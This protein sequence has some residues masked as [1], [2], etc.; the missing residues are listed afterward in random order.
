MRRNNLAAGSTPSPAPGAPGDTVLVTG[1]STGLG[2]ETAL[3]L[4]AKGFTVYATVRDLGMK[5][6]VLATAAERGVELRVLRLDL[7]DQSS[8]DAA[9][10]QILAETGSIFALVNNGGVGLRG[11]LED[12]SDADIRAV[13][14]A[15]LFGTI[16]VTKAVLPSM[17]AA[18][19]GRVV[20]IGSVGGRV[21]S[22]GVSVY[23]SSKFAQ[24]GLA[25]ALYLELA[26]FGLH[27]ILIE[28]GII[29]TTRWSTNRATSEGARNPASAYRPLFEAGEVLA[30]RV[31]N[32]S[33][34][35]AADVADAVAESLTAAKPRLRYV[36]GQPAG[37]VILLR[38]Y[39]PNRT[40]ERVYFGGLLRQLTREAKNHPAPVPS[41]PAQVVLPEVTGSAAIAEAAAQATA[42]SSGS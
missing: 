31:V 32:R 40:F 24:E 8:I 41:V 20:T 11:C 26:P 36:V 38:R 6:E 16:A 23:C 21:S 35:T 17:R 30:D 15:N 34:T 39:L 3:G 18:G 12:L 25:E 27:S 29:K 42:G 14:E 28:P 5:D 22:F 37:L 4:A 33:R 9:I 10:E 2:L 13:F 19:R 1:S 7:T